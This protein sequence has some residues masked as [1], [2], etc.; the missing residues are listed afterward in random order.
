MSVYNLQT[1]LVITDTTDATATNSGA[2]RIGGG[3][4]VTKTLFVGSAV[5]AT[6]LKMTQPLNVYWGLTGAISMAA[7]A[8][9]TPPSSVWGTFTNYTKL[10]TSVTL[11]TLMNASGI[12]TIPFTG[13]YSMTLTW[14][15]NVAASLQLWFNHSVLGRLGAYNGANANAYTVQSINWTGLL[16]AGDLLTP[17]I[18]STTAMSFPASSTPSAYVT[19]SITLLSYC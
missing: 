4:S 12:I 1:P 5:T 15:P 3:A 8:I 14:D 13:I 6:G 16:L 11:N 7:N 19:M 10:P 2:L 17:T 9:Y 18:A